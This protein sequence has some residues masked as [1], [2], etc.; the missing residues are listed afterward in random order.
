M[1]RIFRRKCN[2]SAGRVNFIT[3]EYYPGN[4]PPPD[5]T[6]ARMTEIEQKVLA[7][8]AYNPG[9]KDSVLADAED[10][11]RSSFSAAKKRLAAKGMFR[12][13]FV[14]DLLRFGYEI[15]FISYVLFSAA[16]EARVKRL[17]WK[18]VRGRHRHFFTVADDS[19]LL[20]MFAARNYTEVIYRTDVFEQHYARHGFLEQHRREYLYFPLQLS[21]IHS[22]FDFAPLVSG[23]T[24]DSVA[25]GIPGRMAQRDIA[26]HTSHHGHPPIHGHPPHHGQTPH[27]GHPPS[28]GQTPHHGHPHV[29]TA[30]Q[31]PPR[32][33]PPDLSPAEQRLLEVIFR[34]PSLRPGPL[35][36]AT[37]MGRTTADKLLKDLV[38]RGLIEK[39]I[40]LPPGAMGWEYM[41]AFRLTFQAASS[42]ES[43]EPLTKA[44]MEFHPVLFIENKKEA[45]LIILSSDYRQM[46]EL[47]AALQ[48]IYEN[49]GVLEE[50]PSSLVF[51][52]SRLRYEV[53][54]DF[55]SNLFVGDGEQ[56]KV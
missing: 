47:A 26:D 40:F 15:L 33:T 14:P 10:I 18:H 22:F 56:G 11:A 23:G 55:C 45:F 51:V 49:A 42:V 8:M 28:Y 48:R 13:I 25:P 39:K 29:A 34:N 1:C 19:R 6:L 30:M 3:D 38:G 7:A 46:N 5:R 27:H 44:V 24:G 17:S 43:R 32:M 20:T 53:W 31:A 16:A 9:T 2:I 12:E 4:M 36:K 37:G 50:A 54:D 41:G 52:V 35:G 21:R